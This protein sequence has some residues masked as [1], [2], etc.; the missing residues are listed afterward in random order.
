MQTV[1]VGSILEAISVLEPED[2]LFVT[3]VLNKRAIEIRRN[4]ILARA[5]EAEENYRNGNIQTVTVT[6]LMA[7]S[8]DND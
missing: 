1:T 2:Q 6:E 4:Q 3:E 7:L 5:R 8:A